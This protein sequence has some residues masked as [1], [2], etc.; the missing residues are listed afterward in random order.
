MFTILLLNDRIQYSGQV[1]EI[2]VII[3]IRDSDN[4]WASMS[5]SRMMRKTRMKFRIIHKTNLQ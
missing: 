4:E 1:C 5:E 2:S 3:K